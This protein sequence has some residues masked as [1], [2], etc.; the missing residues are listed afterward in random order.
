ML[1]S[2]KPRQTLC[3]PMDC[4]SQVTLS[5]TISCSL[6]N[7]C[8]LNWWC[9]LT[10][11]SSAASF[12]F[13]LQSFPASGSFP[14]NWLFAS[15]AKVLELYYEYSGLISFRIDWFDLLATQR[16]LKNLF[17]NHN[18]KASILWTQPSLWSNSLHDCWKDHSFDYVNLCWQ[19]AISAF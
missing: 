14:M 16:T 6:L 11:S 5:S 15:V 13:C 18:S 12:S 3:D 4:S 9:Y 10:I 19:S 7:S 2:C 8:P 1:F 17:Q